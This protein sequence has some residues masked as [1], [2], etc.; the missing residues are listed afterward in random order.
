METSESKRKRRGKREKDMHYP[1]ED[2]DEMYDS[3]VE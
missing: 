2:D 3:D 1:D